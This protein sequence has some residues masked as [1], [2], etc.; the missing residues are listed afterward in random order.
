[1]RVFAFALSLV[2][3][4]GA[5]AQSRAP[6]EVALP[7]QT[8][9]KLALG[10]DVLAE[11]EAAFAGLAPDGALF[12]LGPGTTREIQAAAD[13]ARVFLL[14]LQYDLD[15][16]GAVSRGEYDAHG[17]VTW[18][19][20]LDQAARDVL[21]REWREGDQ[22]ANGSIT[23]DEMLALGLTRH[24]VPPNRPLTPV[25]QAILG[26]DLDNDGFVYWDEVERVL[27]ER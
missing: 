17:D 18:G 24:P 25:E 12:I 22:N 11:Y 8:T 5:L 20:D 16:D 9:A 14:Y 15:G 7:T 1:M 19:T 3:A 10:A 13:R 23:A 6:S 27:T 2:V 21:E 26:M 4:G